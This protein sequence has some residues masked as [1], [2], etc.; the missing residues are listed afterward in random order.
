MISHPQSKTEGYILIPQKGKLRH[1][2]G[3]PGLSLCLPLG[4]GAGP[5][6]SRGEVSASK[7]SLWPCPPT[8]LPPP[9]PLPA[10]PHPFPRE[11]PS[12]SRSL[13]QCHC[14]PPTRGNPGPGL[15]S[16]PS[17]IPSL[18]SSVHNTPSPTTHVWGGK[19][20][21]SWTPVWR[22]RCS[23]P[24]QPPTRPNTGS[25]EAE[26]GTSLKGDQALG[27]RGGGGGT[28]EPPLPTSC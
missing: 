28:M 5:R 6:A 1:G 25:E 10:T 2:E 26:T 19:G 18:S 22:L 4:L 27:R 24:R 12:T 15:I 3:R 11:T 7:P 20:P 8:L 13:S 23:V 16:G 9:P 21:C 17:D 14:P